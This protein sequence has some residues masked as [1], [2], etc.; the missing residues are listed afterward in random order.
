[1]L[2]YE[3]KAM[4]TK[5]EYEALAECCRGMFS[6]DQINYYF[7]TDDFYMNRKGITC[8][9]RGKNGKYVT[10][11][12]NHDTDHLNCS[13]EENIYEG[14]DFNCKFFDALGLH[15]QG[16]LI[17]S[18]ITM[19]KDAF[20]EVVIDRNTYLGYTDFEIEVEYRKD[21]E[22]KAIEYLNG[23]AE[24]LYASKLIDSVDNFMLR[25]RKGKSKS[26]RFFEK[27]RFE[28]K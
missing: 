22:A 2:E 20:C 23:V 27:K 12:K 15:L 28:G 26:E 17:T 8:R 4:L 3:K 13:V 21:S 19:Y 10:T 7:D 25:T 24:G 11:I 18:R 6:E 14:D 16:E 1:M 9:I 5:E